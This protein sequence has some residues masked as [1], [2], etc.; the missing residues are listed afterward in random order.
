MPQAMGANVLS[1]HMPC[2]GWDGRLSLT[3]GV[4]TIDGAGSTRKGI[5]AEANLLGK[6]KSGLLHNNLTWV[7]WQQSPPMFLYATCST[8]PHMLRYSVFLQL[9][10]EYTRILGLSLYTNQPIRYCWFSAVLG[11]ELSNHNLNHYICMC[12]FGLLS[13][14]G[15]P[16]E[17]GCR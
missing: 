17:T 16:D 9:H 14:V 10:I 13:A 7:S 8:V 12:R 4:G 6:L 3:V 11:E 1:L 15:S 5:T 2:A